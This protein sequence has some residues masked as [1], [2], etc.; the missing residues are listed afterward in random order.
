VR[1]HRLGA[2]AGHLVSRE[3]ASGDLARHEA[4][5]YERFLDAC[6]VP[7][8][9]DAFDD[10]VDGLLATTPRHDA[11]ID[12]IAAPALHRALPMSRREASQPGVWRFLAVAHRP[13]FVRHRWEN[14]SWATMR[15]RFWSPGTRP[16][17]NA[18]CRLWWIAELTRDG[19]SYRLTDEVFARQA[20]ATNLFV[21]T[22]GHHRPAVTAFLEAMGDSPDDVER[23]ARALNRSLGTLVLETLGHDELVALVRELRDAG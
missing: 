13:D 4:S 18:F 2:E 10:A 16:D 23:V 19:A 1:L 5:A 6:E 11:G 9:L 12:R 20:L 15:T 17:S 14:R 8:E 3:L 7:V 21:R 22:I